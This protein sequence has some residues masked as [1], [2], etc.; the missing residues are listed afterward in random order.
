MICDI[1]NSFKMLRLFSVFIVTTDVNICFIWI[2]QAN[3]SNKID[4][5]NSLYSHCLM[6]CHFISTSGTVSQYCMLRSRS[7]IHPVCGNESGH[8][9]NQ[10][11]IEKFT[12]SSECLARIQSGQ[13]DGRARARALSLNPNMARPY[14]PT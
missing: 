13:S 12:R 10:F 6:S 7:V 3:V 5:K 2:V 11:L 9:D 1:W 4:T 8:A 14:C